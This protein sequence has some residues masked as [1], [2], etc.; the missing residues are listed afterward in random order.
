MQLFAPFST[1]P[2][3]GSLLNARSHYKTEVKKPGTP[4]TIALPI[5]ARGDGYNPSN[6][7]C[8]LCLLEKWRILHPSRDSSWLGYIAQQ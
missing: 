5:Q 3:G 8:H 1:L 4:H 7:R 2:T 6:K